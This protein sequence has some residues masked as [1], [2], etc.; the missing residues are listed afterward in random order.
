VSLDLAGFGREAMPT[1]T[2]PPLAAACMHQREGLH[3]LPRNVKT[4]ASIAGH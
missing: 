4:Q 2:P 3:Q 1:S